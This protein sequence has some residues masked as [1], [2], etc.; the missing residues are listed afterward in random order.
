VLLRT[1]GPEFGMRVLPKRNASRTF[2]VQQ[3]FHADAFPAA[4]VAHDGVIEANLPLA[5]DAAERMAIFAL[6]PIAP[7]A[8]NPA[9]LHK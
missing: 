1:L 9:H 4:I 3:E 7:A 8:V 2:T 6:G 5:G